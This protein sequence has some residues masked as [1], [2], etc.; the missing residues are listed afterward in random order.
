M[1]ARSPS[2][3]RSRK[4]VAPPILQHLPPNSAGS[5]PTAAAISLARA[6]EFFVVQ[7]ITPSSAVK[8][9][10]SLRQPCVRSLTGTVCSRSSQM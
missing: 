7:G 3:I 5:R 9:G 4:S 1:S 2:P 8:N 10:V 6:L